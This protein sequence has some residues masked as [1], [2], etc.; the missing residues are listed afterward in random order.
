MSNYPNQLD[1]DVEL[2]PINDNIDQLGG[3]AINGLRDSVINIE[4]AL[5]VNIA[6]TAPDLATRLNV[7]INSDGT[8]NASIIYSL[9]LVVLPITNSQVSETAGIQESK[10]LLDYRTQDLFNYI[11]DLAKDVNLAIGWIS[12]SGIKLEPHLIGAIYRHDLAQIDVAETSTQFLNNVFRAVRDNTNAYTLINDI[13]NELLVHQWADGSTFGIEQNIITNDGST[14]PSYFAHTASGI[15]LDTS[16]FAIIPQTA[17]NVQL[18]ANFF[19]SSSL[20]TLGTRIQ[21]LYANGISVNSRSSSLTTDGYGSPVVPLTPV[22]TYLRG[23]FGNQ[24]IPFDDIAYGDDIIQFFPSSTVTSNNTFDE[25][26]ALVKPGDIIRV[27]YGADGYNVEV[28]YVISEKKYNQSGPNKIFVVRILGKNIAYS[29]NAVARIDRSLFNNNKYGVLSVAGVNSLVPSLIVGSARGA[30]CTG[31]DFSADQFNETHYNLYLAL[32]P[33]GNPLDGYTFLPAIDV[34]GNQGTTP[35]SYTL[36]GI[37]ASTN[38]AFRQPGFNY[39]FMAFEFEGQF[40]IKLIDSY[41]NAS[42]SVVSAVVSPLGMYDQTNTMLNFPFNTID[43]FPAVSTLTTAAT[44]TFPVTTIAVGS[45]TGF[46]SSGTIMVSTSTNGIQSVMY[47]G[48]TPTSFTGVTGGTGTVL[49][50]SSVTQSTAGAQG[51]DPLGFGPFAAGLASPPFLTSYG[52]ARSALLPTILF[53]PL[54]RNNYYVNGAEREVFSLDVSQTQDVYGDGYW[55]AAMDGYVNNPGPPGHVSVTYQIPLDLSASGLKAGK[56]IVVQPVPGGT[57][58]GLVNYGRFIISSIT[59]TCCPPVQTQITVYDAVHAQGGSPYPILPVGSPVAIY[60][61]PDSVSFDNETA[62]DFSPVSATFKRYF[63]VYI[64]DNGDTFTHERGRISLVT[65]TVVNGV[66]LYTSTAIMGQ[67]D[68]VSISPK[69]RGYPY[70]PITK[71]NLFMTSFNPITGRYTANLGTYNGTLFTRPGPIVNGRVGEV[72]RLYDETFIDYIDIFIPLNNTITVIANQYIDVQ[73]LPSLELDEEIMLIASCQERTDTNI[74]NRLQDLRQF[75]NT[76]EEQLTTSALNYIAL[77]EKLLHFNGVIRGFNVT[78]NSV[79]GNDGS[80]S[81]SGGLALVGGTFAETNDQLFTIAPLQEIYGGIPYPINYVVC[82]NSDGDLVTIVLT[83]FDPLL[84]TPSGVP[85]RVVTV[86]NLVSSTT[87][88]VS[89]ATFSYILNNRKDLTALYIVSAVVSGSGITST[90]NL[91]PENVGS[92]R[93]VRRFVNDSD[94]SIPAVLT[95]DTSQGNFD[96]LGA[97][98]NWLTFNNAFQDT[99]LVKGAY[100]ISNDP[101]FNFPLFVEGSGDIASFT[102]LDNINMSNVTF[103]NMTLVFTGSLTATNVTFT[104]CNLTFDF[105]TTFVDVIIDPSVVNVNSFITISGSSILNS[106]VNCATSQP[107]ILGNNNIFTGNVFTNQFNPVGDGVYQTSN[108]VNSSLAVFYANVTTSLSNITITNN[109]LVNILPDH[110]PFFSLQLST[111]TAIC[112]NINISNNQFTNLSSSND[113]RAVIALT[114]TVTSIITNTYPIYPKLVNVIIENNICNYD[115]MILIS[116]DRVPGTPITGPML[117]TVN[118]RISSNTCGTIG[119]INSA[120]EV[121][122]VDDSNSI[123]GGFIRNKAGQLII[124]KNACKLITNLDSIG[125]YIAFFVGALPNPLNATTWVNINTGAY[126]IVNNSVN[127]IQVGCAGAYSVQHNGALISGNRISPNDPA[128]LNQYIDT[129]QSGIAPAN[130]GILLRAEDSLSGSPTGQSESIISNNTISQNPV[131][132]I[133]AGTTTPFFYLAA[134]ACFTNAIISNNNVCGVVNSS[135]NPILYLWS[136]GSMRVMG[137]VLSRFDGANNYNIQAYVLGQVGATNQVSITNNTFDEQ[138]V[139]SA[140]TNNQTGLNIPSAWEFRNNVNQTFYVEVPLVDESAVITL[141]GALGV[142]GDPFGSPPVGVTP[143]GVILSTDGID[144]EFQRVLAGGT[145]SAQYAVV[146]D[147]QTA[148]FE[149]T[150]FSKMFSLDYKIPPSCRLI[151][152]DMGITL[153]VPNLTIS[154]FQQALDWSQL[155]APTPIPGSTNNCV[156]LSLLQYVHTTT[157]QTFGN[158]LD[159]FANTSYNLGSITGDATQ[160]SPNIIYNIAIPN[161]TV[162]GSQA[163]ETLWRTS[164]QYAHIP[165]TAKDIRTGQSYRIAISVDSTFLKVTTEPVFLVFSPVVVTCVYG[166]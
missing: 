20:L 54:R 130:V 61:N 27:N 62:T 84:V 32:Y 117:N 3:D 141:G 151:S 35:G 30:E 108:L 52:S 112:Q 9:G 160:F 26:F 139:D 81:F 166:V 43:L 51:P 157:A 80:L 124:E 38:Q 42:F 45:T 82:I 119:F 143:Q 29:P 37:V 41:N 93:D 132:E 137:N 21:N 59:F 103:E 12:V 116:T 16:R 134:I 125:D 147:F 66:N 100:T 6:G 85:D 17:D 118:C 145:A 13:N 158:V 83:D 25:Q 96:T 49:I 106:T 164:T 69:L 57:N 8:P 115:Q 24:S 111:Q 22:I 104:N 165:L 33:D 91:Q 79:A 126:S 67:I 71:I 109:Q 28:P 122:H 86:M 23:Q 114:S 161:S 94:S 19:D 10:L 110:Y 92:P 2:P 47:T 97:A 162:G 56:T 149:Q 105:L 153:T 152:I 34:T 53:A 68:L 74:V 89:S 75:G 127:W 48:T 40:G 18:F 87:Y 148:D 113:I 65:G 131:S 64:D 46:T 77:P 70:G 133:G 58:F 163:A 121:S 146:S 129:A 73:L 136:Q 90:V 150:S 50:N 140:F 142:Q 14:Y 7:F 156:T 123:N 15:F 120:N 102:F 98:L 135:A 39:R 60:F 5:G 72:T 155:G 154:P 78:V 88:Q 144:L 159:V 76:S 107:F 63:E 31:V 55:V 99:L 36:S 11:R 95:N 1:T 44:L 128:Y 4:T 138:Y 101:G